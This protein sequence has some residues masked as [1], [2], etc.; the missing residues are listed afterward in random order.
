M[1]VEKVQKE[2][3]EIV[4]IYTTCSGKEEARKLALP[5]IESKLAIGADYWVINSI[6]PWKNVIQE[7][8]QYMIMFATEKTKGSLLIKEIEAEHPYSVPMIVMQDTAL[9]NHS[10]SFWVETTLTNKE[11]YLTEKEYEKNK[12]AEQTANYGKLK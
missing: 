7:I 4:F 10:Y 12:K 6:Y 5:I 2:I 11:R 3:K 1:L 9:T 8:D